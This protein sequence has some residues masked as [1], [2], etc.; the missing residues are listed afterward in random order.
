MGNNLRP[1]RRN[2]AYFHFATA[3]L[4]IT[5]FAILDARF[6]FFKSNGAK[7]GK[8]RV[9]EVTGIQQPLTGD[10]TKHLSPEHKHDKIFPSV[11]K[12]DKVDNPKHFSLT[13]MVVDHHKDISWFIPA[14]HSKFYAG[15][16]RTV[17]RGFLDKPLACTVKFFGIGLEPSLDGFIRGGTGYLSM[18]K[19]SKY[20]H[21]YDKNETNKV[22]CYYM[23]NK[24]YGSEFLTKPKTLGIVVS[25]PIWLD[26]EIGEFQFRSTIP[27]GYYC[28]LLARI[29]LSVY[30]TLR[31]TS[32]K[33]PLHLGPDIPI[34]T[35]TDA[36]SIPENTRQEACGRSGRKISRSSLL[37]SQL[38][39]GFPHLC[40]Y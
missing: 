24:D 5:Y 33:V 17:S 22:H 39:S 23:T 6:N 26:S 28:S 16:N 30:V 11:L 20:Y 3:V 31:P 10:T 2:K 34:H 19:G 8:D 25:C 15:Y 13:A 18:H 4:L 38:L 29:T 9:L 1:S 40:T 32:Y 12:W 36:N 14:Q 7:R 37:K 21:G 27:P 35:T